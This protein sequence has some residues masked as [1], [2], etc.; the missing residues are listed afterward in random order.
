M[1]QKVLDVFVNISLYSVLVP[2]ILV[3]I[4]IQSKPRYLNILGLLILISF[5][6]DW[7]PVF[8]PRILN[9]SGNF[10]SVLEFILLIIIFDLNVRN[11]LFKIALRIILIVFILFSFINMLFIEGLEVRNANIRM[12]STL[13]FTIISI[14]YFVMMMKDP[15]QKKLL[16]NSM[17][18]INAGVLIYFTGNLI[19][20]DADMTFGISRIYAIYLIIHSSLNVLKNI[21]YGVALGINIKFNRNGSIAYR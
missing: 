9:Y 16:S 20:S 11:R 10:Y 2:L 12:V 4:K 17:F 5:L 21:F 18:W 15:D 1:N 13:S 7:T 3:F 6:A 8:F 14:L 19:L